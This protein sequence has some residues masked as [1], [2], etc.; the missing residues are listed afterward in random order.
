M[1]LISECYYVRAFTQKHLSEVNHFSWNLII[2]VVLFKANGGNRL[3]DT[4]DSSGVIVRSGT[5]VSF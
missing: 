1:S 3:R 5:S 2:N 4:T